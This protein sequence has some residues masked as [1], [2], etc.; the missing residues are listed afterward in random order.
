M[1][2]EIESVKNRK[3]KKGGG[4]RDTVKQMAEKKDGEV[5]RCMKGERAITARPGRRGEARRKGPPTQAA[6]NGRYLRLR[7]GGEEG[8]GGSVVY[9]SAPQITSGSSR[10]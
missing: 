2:G 8:E 3:E 10:P 1:Q 5:R 6:R 9:L 7:G 4:A